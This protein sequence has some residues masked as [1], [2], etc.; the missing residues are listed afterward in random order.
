MGL[1]N[2]IKIKFFF[3]AIYC[4][5]SERCLCL[6]CV[7]LLTPYY[8]HLFDDKFIFKDT[9]GTHHRL[10]SN[11]DCLRPMRYSISHYLWNKTNQREINIHSILLLQNCV[12]VESSYHEYITPTPIQKT[13]PNR[14]MIGFSIILA[15]NQHQHLLKDHLCFILLEKHLKSSSHADIFIFAV[16]STQNGPCEISINVWAPPPAGCN[17]KS[18]YLKR[19]RCDASPTKFSILPHPVWHS[20]CANTPFNGPAQE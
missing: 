7:H 11:W 4:N 1:Q 16:E 17:G 13:Q 6:M 12:P 19:L 18:I 5:G 8:I 15:Q 9:M 20:L 3:V 10:M 14:D 2:S